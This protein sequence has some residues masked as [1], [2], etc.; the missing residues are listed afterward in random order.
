MYS[1][2]SQ[3]RHLFLFYPCKRSTFTTSAPYGGPSSTSRLR[4]FHP[5]I[6]LQLTRRLAGLFLFSLLSFTVL[7]C[8]DCPGFTFCPLLYNTHNTNIYAPGGIRTRNPIT[9]A[10]TDLRSRPRNRQDR[11]DSNPEPISP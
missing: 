2:T 8:P 9:L 4:R 6:K 1:A 3:K 5:G 10:A 11:R 7:L